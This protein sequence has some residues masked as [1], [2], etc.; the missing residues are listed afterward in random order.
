MTVQETHKEY[1]SL[2]NQIRAKFEQLDSGEFGTVGS[3][4]FN[5]GTCVPFMNT[6][7]WRHLIST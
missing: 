5:P 1:D 6:I 4:A 2:I 7:E 3:L